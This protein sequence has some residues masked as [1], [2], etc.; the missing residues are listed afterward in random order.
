LAYGKNETNPAV[1]GLQETSHSAASTEKE[2]SL[3]FSLNYDA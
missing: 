2:Q 1:N 3:T